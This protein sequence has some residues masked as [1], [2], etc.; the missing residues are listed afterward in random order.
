[1]TANE[2]KAIFAALQIGYASRAA[3]QLIGKSVRQ[4]Q[5]YAAGEPIPETVAILLRL[6]LANSATEKF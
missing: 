3:A 1:M 5:R 4:S 6:Y 2:Y